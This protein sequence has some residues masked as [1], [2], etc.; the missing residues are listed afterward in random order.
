MNEQ[1]DKMFT[2]QAPK[3]EDLRKYSE[4]RQK[5]KEFAFLIDAICPASQERSIAIQRLQ[6]VSM[7]AN[8]SI[9]LN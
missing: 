3:A 6:E 5:A 4:I 1:L 9:A 2:Y 8:A 7:W